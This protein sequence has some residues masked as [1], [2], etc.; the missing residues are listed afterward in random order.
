[1]EHYVVD[2]IKQV[3]KHKSAPNQYKFNAL[4]FLKE[5]MKQ[6]PKQLVEYV[7]SKILQRLFVLA[8]SNMAEKCLL[9]Y[10]KTSDTTWSANF[11]HL[12]LETLSNWG[13]MFR[14]SNQEYQKVVQ[15]LII[16]RRLPIASKFYPIPSDEILQNKSLL[17][18]GVK[19]QFE[20]IKAQRNDI[21][22]M[23]MAGEFEDLNDIHLINEITSYQNS[24]REFQKKPQ[25]QSMLDNPNTIMTPSQRQFAEDVGRETVFG[26]Q[27][28]EVFTK[29]R[30][31]NSPVNFLEKFEELNGIF[32]DN[33]PINLKNQIERFRNKPNVPVTQDDLYLE[34]NQKPSLMESGVKN[35][36]KDING[37]NTQLESPHLQKINRNERLDREKDQFRDPVIEMKKDHNPKDESYNFNLP[38]DLKINKKTDYDFEDFS[39]DNLRDDYPQILG[40]K[41]GKSSNDL[42]KEPSPNV[43]GQNKVI[44]NDLNL[45]SKKQKID[46]L[47]KENDE[48]MRDIAMLEDKKKNLESKVQ[49]Y[50]VPSQLNRQNSKNMVHSSVLNQQADGTRF[51]NILKTKDDHIDKLAGKI[52]RLE[53]EYKKMSYIGESPELTPSSRR[54]LYDDGNLLLTPQK[55]E[56]SN[57]RILSGNGSDWKPSR[58]Q[59][60]QTGSVFVN[61]MYK[62]INRL[63]N[64][65]TKNN[66]VS[67]EYAY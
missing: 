30:D 38:Q 18:Q 23:L 11:H 34:R 40:R 49:K 26:E 32:F 6:K 16:L 33:E 24:L 64:K 41:P 27:F 10:N 1:M 45:S 66:L 61:Q 60:E 17:D 59:S 46:V 5:L 29:L 62:D 55:K 42:P 63:L 37:Y 21:R 28:Q 4:L 14:A 43:I 36:L 50:Q 15:K 13:Q 48:L 57:R 8:S 65:P 20:M 54:H 3:I 39:N 51:Y 44:G 19:G 67:R 7:Q 52:S 2:Y 31:E 25:I 9:Q 47:F 58:L 12:N 53:N 35:Q 22:N 56:M